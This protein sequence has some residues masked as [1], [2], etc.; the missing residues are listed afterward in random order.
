MKWLL[1]V[2]ALGLVSAGAAGCG[3]AGYHRGA[4][5]RASSSTATSAEVATSQPAMPAG[6]TRTTPPT[7]APG[8]RYLNDA[9]NDPTGD[10]DG[11]DATPGHFVDN[12]NDPSED[13]YKPENNLYHDADDGSVLKIGSPA[14]AADRRAVTETVKRYYAAAASGDSARACSM[15]VAS[16]AKS[17]PEV[18]GQA[19][20]PPYLRG[21]KT[22][23]TLLA[24]YFKHFSA[25][26]ANAF[27][28]TGVRVQ[29]NRGAALLGSKKMP[30]SSILLNR[31]HG[32]W[33][34]EG[35][36]GGQLP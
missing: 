21:L 23:P 6:A 4:A 19:T 28:V 27:V 32:V 1:V 31:E 11:D 35:L 9:D 34:I 15:I 25:Q 3:S 8:Q 2:F 10:G 14:S 13:R 36:L 18:Y 29:G 5:S 12:D 33:K 20:G 16:F 17:I 30:A 26:L 22:C 24:R 7:V